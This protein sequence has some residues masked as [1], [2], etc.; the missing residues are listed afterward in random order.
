MVTVHV[1]IGQIL[2]NIWYAVFL[3]IS[4][5][6]KN[7][8]PILNINISVN[9]SVKYNCNIPKS[10]LVFPLFDASYFSLKALLV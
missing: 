5:T 8:L 1:S 10:K 3:H 7:M 6:S 9:F 2:I 4:D